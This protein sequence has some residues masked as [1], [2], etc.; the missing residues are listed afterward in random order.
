M[1]NLL[2]LDDMQIIYPFIKI[3]NLSNEDQKKY[4]LY[5][6]LELPKEYYPW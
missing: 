5:Y 1:N 2:K 3:K 6:E 4:E